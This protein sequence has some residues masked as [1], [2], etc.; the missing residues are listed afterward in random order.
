MTIF[1]F[2]LKRAL[3]S[4]V[5]IL[6]LAVLPAG[7]V[8]VPVVPGSTL[9]LGFHLYGQVIMF[10]A[11]LMVR[12]TVEDRLSGTLAR[13]SDHLGFLRTVLPLAQSDGADVID[14]YVLPPA[15]RRRLEAA[16][17]SFPDA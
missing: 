12:S 9:P 6:L 10:A 7:I 1:L 8:F 11:F 3:R 16:I 17:A 14:F 5:N 13:I 4:P 2:T 15:E